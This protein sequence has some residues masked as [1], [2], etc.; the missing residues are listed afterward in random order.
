MPKAHLACLWTQLSTVPC[1]PRAVAESG[2]VRRSSDTCSALDSPSWWS[3]AYS[4][5]LTWSILEDPL[6]GD[7]ER[8]ASYMARLMAL[9]GDARKSG[10]GIV[11][12]T[13]SSVA[14]NGSVNAFTAGTPQAQPGTDRP[15]R[16]F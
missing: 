11:R 6:G 10:D 8:N 16:L 3:P 5:L 4:R 1:R 2:A 13:D 12:A 15:V 9:L 14:I 7:V